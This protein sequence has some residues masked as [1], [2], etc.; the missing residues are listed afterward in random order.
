MPVGVLQR[1]VVVLHEVGDAQT[2]R[3][4]DPR[5][6]VHQG[7]ASALLDLSDL[8]ADA[9]EVDAEVGAGHVVDVDLDAVDAGEVQVGDVHGAVDDVGDAQTA[10][11]LPADRCG[12]AQIQV[13]SDLGDLVE[14]VAIHRS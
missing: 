7:L 13:V 12:T 2:G 3:A 5:H 4:A 11:P 10:D 1:L 9:V 14:H 8:V 6:A